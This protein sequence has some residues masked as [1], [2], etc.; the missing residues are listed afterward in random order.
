MTD[1]VESIRGKACRERLA[2]LSG[3][4]FAA[5]VA[6]GK[7]TSVCAVSCEPALS[8]YF[9]NLF[10]TDK[11]R[12]YTQDDVLGVELGGSLKNVMAIA[13]GVCDGMELGENARAALITR[14]LAEMVRLG[15][16]MGA[17][18]ETFAGLTGMG[19]LILTCSGKQSRNH[20]FG[21]LLAKGFSC[22]EAQKKSAW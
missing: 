15:V 2:V 7:P 3:P 19:D 1:L 20:Q 16:A 9:Q 17:R 11:F 18:P 8:A 10:M 21:E 22:E 12:V 14:G 6:V 13:A 5:E 4:S